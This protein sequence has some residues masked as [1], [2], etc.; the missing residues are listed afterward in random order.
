MAAFCGFCKRL[1]TS[2]QSDSRADAPAP[3]PSGGKAESDSQL[4]RE[5]AR[6]IRVCSTRSL[7]VSSVT[8]QTGH[9]VA[10]M[11]PRVLISPTHGSQ[12]E[13]AGWPT[14]RK[15]Q[16]KTPSLRRLSYITIYGRWSN[17]LMHVGHLAGRCPSYIAMQK[18]Y[19]FF[20]GIL[21]WCD[22]GI[23][24]CTM[25][26]LDQALPREDEDMHVS[27]YLGSVGPPRFQ[28]ASW[29]GGSWVQTI[30]RPWPT[31]PKVPRT[32]YRPGRWNGQRTGRHAST[33][34]QGSDGTRATRNPSPEPRSSTSPQARV[35][36]RQREPGLCQHPPR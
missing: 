22:S 15:R 7:G 28:G 35:V 12:P 11:A 10:I 24:I 27:R 25:R 34:L 29:P 4:K 5:L 16:S 6:Q 23:A 18:R 8:A 36:E 17:S 2:G 21:F 31:R 3:A 19:K 26:R 20:S 30:G 1:F 32:C 33:H 13:G 9:L 14:A